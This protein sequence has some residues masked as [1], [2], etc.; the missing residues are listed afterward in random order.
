MNEKKIPELCELS[1][2][3]AIYD[4]DRQEWQR[5]YR[6]DIAILPKTY[7]LFWDSIAQNQTNQAPSKDIIIDVEKAESIAVQADTTPADN[8]STSVDIN[9]MSSPDGVTWDTVPYAEMNLGDAQI[10]T[11]LINPG[12]LKIRLRLDE[13]NTGIAECRVRVKVKE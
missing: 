7:E 3:V 1:K 6:K 13:N 11:M 5:G 10:K 2:Q 9:V 12:P 8:A 4:H